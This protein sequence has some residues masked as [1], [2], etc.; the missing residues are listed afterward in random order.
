MSND[1]GSV[2]H[3]STDR[4]IDRGR[5]GWG[6]GEIYDGASLVINLANKELAY[7]SHLTRCVVVR[8]NLWQ[9][10]NLPALKFTVVSI[11][12]GTA[13]RCGKGP[14][15]IG[16][17]IRTVVGDGGRREQTVLSRDG[18]LINKLDRVGGACHC[19]CVAI[20]GKGWWVNWWSVDLKRWL[21]IEMVDYQ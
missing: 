6:L 17:N 19:G 20:I 3:V 13:G 7:W 12:K 21:L 15:C 11:L 10:K 4:E 18:T 16:V 14:P 8:Q 9:V 5:N 2:S 1:S